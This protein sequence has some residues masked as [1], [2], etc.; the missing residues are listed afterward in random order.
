MIKIPRRR[1]GAEQPWRD[2]AF[3][4]AEELQGGQLGVEPPAP[5][6]EVI[7]PGPLEHDG[8]VVISKAEPHDMAP[9]PDLL[10]ITHHHARV[11]AAGEQ[12]FRHLSLS[13]RENLKVS[14]RVGHTENRIPAPLCA[15][16]PIFL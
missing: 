13:R 4:R 7:L 16:N 8:A 5:I 1:V 9:T 10:G 14:R 15:R 2:R 3:H 12:R 11:P 6:A